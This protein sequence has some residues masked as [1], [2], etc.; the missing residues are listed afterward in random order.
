[1][2][3]PLGS[4]PGTTRKAEDP[5]LGTPVRA[6]VAS[7]TTGSQV[8]PAP[9]S[10]TVGY[11]ATTGIGVVATGTTGPCPTAITSRAG[12]AT[13]ATTAASV[14]L[15]GATGRGTGTAPVPTGIGRRTREPGQGNRFLATPVSSTTRATPSPTVICRALATADGP[16]STSGYSPSIASAI[17]ISGTYGRAAPTATGAATAAF[18]RRT[19]AGASLASISRRASD[20]ATPAIRA[21]TVGREPVASI[22]VTGP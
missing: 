8:R 12:S 19:V 21:A 10:I 14:A 3:A 17:G 6:P 5:D 7:R 4:R 1:M 22:S 16:V 13:G 2:R 20:A 11:A 18:T 15:A 9:T